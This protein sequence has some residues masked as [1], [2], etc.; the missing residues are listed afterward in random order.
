M[1][2]TIT[3]LKVGLAALCL[4]LAASFPNHAAYGQSIQIT[5]TVTDADNGESI[6]GVNISQKGTTSGTITDLDG[7][8][9]LQAPGDGILVFSF[10]GYTTQEVPIN[11]QKSI[12]VTLSSDVTGLEEVVVVGYG[13]QKKADLTGAVSV[14]KMDEMSQQP[15]ANLTSQLQGRVSGVTITGSGQPGQAPQVKIRGVNTFGNNTPLYVVDGVP[16]DGINDLNPNDVET[17]QVLKDAGA[18]SIY[19]SRAANGVIIVTTKRGRGDVKVN[20]NMYIG[21]QTV[22]SGNPWNILNPQEMANLKFQAIR[23]GNP[24]AV[25]NDEQYGSGPNPV[26]PNYI[27]PAGSQTVDESTYNV[28]PFYTDAQDL[29]NFN[30][31]VEANKSGTNWFQE[32]FA[33]ARIQSHNLSVSG[34]G[35]QGNYFFSTNY[36]EQQGTLMNTY[37]KRYTIRANSVYNV[38]KNIRIGENLGYSISQNPTISNLDEGSAIGMSFRQQPIIPVYDI[39]GN[40]AGSFGPGLGNAKNS[41]AIQERTANNRGVA[42]RLFG[43]VFAEVDFLKHFKARTSFGGQYYANSYNRFQFPEYENSENLSVN[44]YTEGANFNFNYTWT[45]TVTYTREINDK[46]N[47]SILAGTEAYKN[48][49]RNMEG[50]TQGYFSFDPNYVTLTNGSGTQQHTSSLYKD[51]LFSI[52]GRVDYSYDDRYIVSAT[53]RRDGSSRFL[54]EQFGVFPAISAGWRVSEEDFM[55]ESN[56]LDDLKI[57]GGYGVMGNQLNVA[58]DNSFST[59]E[60]VKNSS[61][62][63]IDGSN[64]VIT[65]GFQQKRIGNPDAKWERNINSNIGVDASL[66]QGKLQLTIDYY[67]KTVD[68][69]LYNPEVIATEGTAEPPYINI[70][71]MTNKG[72]DFDASTYFTISKDLTFN[73]SLSFTTYSNE[74]VKI[75]D[76]VPYFDQEGR[77]FNGSN[78]IRNQVGRPVS[79]FFGYQVVGFWDS[80]SEVD[81]ANTSASEILNDPNATYQDGIGVGRFKYQDVNG[82]G[83]ITADDRT[84]LGNPNPKFSYGINLGLEYKNW[85]FSMFLYGVS[86]NDI[87]NN[88]KWWTDFYSSFQGA[89]SYTALY[90]SWTPENMNASAPIQES[91]GSF[92]TAGV[93]N[94]YFVEKGSYLRAK[95]TQI[96]Y[97]FTKAQIDRLHLGAL[98]VYV[99][100]ANLFTIT[101]YSGLDPEISGGTT[102][103]GIDEGQYPNQRQFIFGLNV[104]F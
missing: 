39:M 21:T 35:D 99:Q 49:G 15:T 72:L 33:P 86:G 53:V 81:Q 3:H 47:L 82:D 34:G 88:V 83:I 73:T 45:N 44:Q 41:V 22:R 36:F 85:D 90:D 67:T 4:F 103:F 26:L 24:D 68:D 54:N 78:I 71:K 25:I 79:E 76:G 7:K 42:S 102:N 27:S 31:I 19:G 98:R 2:K 87:W 55:P 66:W 94:S 8:F 69:L 28:N 101:K 95:Q 23:N 32:I 46:H 57:R 80:Q 60:G 13:T 96:G 40:F 18:A 11:G 38:T 48:N 12:N 65:E 37:L 43:N 10:I 100:A 5:G 104:S 58:P 84:G 16:T 59:Y 97:N 6:P 93:P 29:D 70:A 9:S 89:K 20:Y 56:W 63:P 62:Y 74:I 64:S 91:Q 75:A 51:A 14:V 30:R 61:Y 50:Y 52:F 92:S 1:K 77:R 17:M